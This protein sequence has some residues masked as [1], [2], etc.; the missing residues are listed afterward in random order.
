MARQKKDF[1]LS[2]SKM[3]GAISITE[4][5][6]QILLPFFEE[7]YLYY[8][9]RY[10]ITGKVRERYLSSNGNNKL[11]E[12]AEDALFF[13]LF[14]IKTY[15]TEESIALT[16]SMTQPQVN[17]WK[18][19][20]QQILKESFEK[21]EFLPA[22]TTKDLNKLFQKLEVKSV[23]IDATERAMNRPKDND[24]QKEFYSG[25]KKFTLSKTQ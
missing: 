8:F 14:Y 1:K 12:S 21:M 9:K 4:E 2:P 15:P 5:E 23:I 25:K 7:C 24:V 3:L 17:Q 20:L 19:V 10:T 18:Q 13:I 16:F 11:F 6:F 22:R